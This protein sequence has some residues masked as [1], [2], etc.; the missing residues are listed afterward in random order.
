MCAAG[1]DIVVSAVGAAGVPDQPKWIEAAKAAGVRRF[2][3]SEFGL[4]ISEPG[5]AQ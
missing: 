3:P 5:M 2:V 1:Q 4:D